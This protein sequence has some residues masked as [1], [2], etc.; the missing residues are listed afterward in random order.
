M[1]LSREE[2]EDIAR[3]TA[4]TVLEG[5]HRYALEY[6]DP[7]TVEQGLQDSMIEE[8][9]AADWYRKRSEH[10][11]GAGAGPVSALYRHIAQEEDNHYEELRSRLEGTDI[12]ISSVT[13]SRNG[14]AKEVGKQD[15][16]GTPEVAIPKAEAVPEAAKIAKINETE[17]EIRIGDKKVAY[18]VG[19]KAW[20]MG[21]ARKGVEQP[22]RW[23][24]IPTKESGISGATN[25]DSPQEALD[26]WNYKT[27]I[28]E[29]G[30]ILP[31]AEA[32]MPEAVPK[33]KEHWQ[34]TRE[35]YVRQ[36]REW[37]VANMPRLTGTALEAELAKVAE[38]HKGVVR[39]A[40]GQGKPV[41]AEV[42]KD[43]PD[44]A[45]S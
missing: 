35:E 17:Y 21:V 14:S 16:P 11:K 8:R 39:Q 23:R 25:I 32:G 2:I 19:E 1:P 45:R 5:L 34:M 6:E 33:V 28:P 36:A 26:I 29:K 40:I 42:L 24:L 43:Y 37:R 3:A 30:K 20:D 18:V 44:L 27:G 13:I 10:A 9:T 38:G 7:E 4:Q 31:K 12:D 41:P 15:N 22:V